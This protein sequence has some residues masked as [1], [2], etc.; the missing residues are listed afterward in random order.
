MIQFG[1]TLRK[2]REAKGLSTDELARST[3][4][5]ARQVEAL[6]REDFSWLA[7]PIY[8]RGF[9]KL[10]CEAVGLDTRMMSEAFMELYRGARGGKKS[11]PVAASVISAAPTPAPAP[12]PTPAPAAPA[13]EP[14]VEAEP[15][16]DPGAFSLV[17]DVVDRHETQ[18]TREDNPFAAMDEEPGSVPRGPSRLAPPRPIDMRRPFKMPSLPHIPRRVWRLVA[19]AACA[20]ALLYLIL[21]G[22]RALFRVATNSPESARTEAASPAAGETPPS[23]KPARDVRTIAPLYI[24]D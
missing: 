4:M 1:E 24:D 18:F 15:D 21:A 3:H 12:A 9:V 8:G 23:A 22:F 10:Y 14:V 13:P 6:E 5:M 2:A 20:A 7:A 16:P 11:A 17:S 19:V